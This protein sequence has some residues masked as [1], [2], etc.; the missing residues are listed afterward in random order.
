YRNEE[1]N[2]KRIGE[3]VYKEKI[4]DPN[5]GIVIDFEKIKVEDYNN[6]HIDD[7]EQG[8]PRRLLLETQSSKWNGN[9]CINGDDASKPN[10]IV[11]MI[12]YIHFRR[13]RTC[14]HDKECGQ[15]ERNESNCRLCRVEHR[16]GICSLLR[17]KTEE[18]GLHTEGV[19]DIQE[20]HPRVHVG[21]DTIFSRMKDRR[22]R[23]DQYEVDDAGQ[24]A[25]EPVD[26]GFPSKSLYLAQ[27]NS[28][29]VGLSFF[30]ER[31]CPLP[32]IIRPGTLGKISRL[33]LI[34]ITSLHR[35]IHAI[36]SLGHG[37]R[38]FRKDSSENLLCQRHKCFAILHDAIHQADTMGLRCVDEVAGKDYL[39]RSS[40]PCKTGKA[41]RAPVAGYDSK[42]YFGLSQ[43]G[44][45]NGDTDVTCHS[46]F[47]ATS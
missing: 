9:E 3:K 47:A 37:N 39:K 22:V 26:S 5:V 13:E 21:D 34:S 20:S 7:P 31:R 14:K 43:L 15:G 16:I 10:D 27:L 2:V 45:L 4:G 18:G 24:D 35:G 29:I 40:R 28:F 19:Q 17:C 38:R 44:M 42:V 46:K 12:R 11:R 6:E 30:Q 36:D 8:K 23:Q 1:E 41:L 25:A 32:E 33:Y